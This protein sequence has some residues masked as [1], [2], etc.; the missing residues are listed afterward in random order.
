MMAS[1]YFGISFFVISICLYCPRCSKQGVDVYYSS[2]R[3]F[4]RW[5]TRTIYPSQM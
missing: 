5:A 3:C 4:V 2:R 1:L